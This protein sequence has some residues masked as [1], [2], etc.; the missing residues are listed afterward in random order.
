MKGRAESRSNRPKPHESNPLGERQRFVQ[1]FRFSPE[2][3][4]LLTTIGLLYMQVRQQCGI[5]ETAVFVFVAMFAWRCWFSGGAVPEGL[6]TPGQLAHVRREQ[7]A[8]HTRSRQHDAGTS[9]SNS[10]HKNPT[11]V[12]IVL[13]PRLS[14]LMTSQ[15]AISNGL[16]TNSTS[17]RILFC[18][19]RRTET[20]M[21]R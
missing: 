12:N 20:T 1:N 17:T 19:R 9:A 5:G 15:T 6:R 8:R 14:V 11:T 10:G 21:W 16:F 7:R 2:N 3:A 4:E 18:L 13:V